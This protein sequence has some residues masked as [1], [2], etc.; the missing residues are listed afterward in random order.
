MTRLMGLFGL[1]SMMVCGLQGQ[2]NDAE[3]V[4]ACVHY[5]ICDMSRI[6]QGSIFDAYASIS[7]P[8]PASVV[9]GFP[10]RTN[11][12]GI[13][14][15]VDAG[16]QT[17]DA[18]I[19]QILSTPTLYSSDT[20][21]RVRAVLPS[22]T[23]LGVASVVVR[24]K[25]TALNGSNGPK[26]L[27]VKRDLG[28][29]NAGP[30]TTQNFSPSGS[31]RVNSFADAATPGQ[32][33]VL[34]GTGL[35][36]VSADEAGGPAPGDL[37]IQDLQVLVANK[38]AHVVYAG[39]SGC[40]AGLDQIMFEVPAETQ[41]CAVP[42]VVRFSDD[43]SE[44]NGISLS[45]AAQSGACPI[46][47][48]ADLT[49]K[50]LSG[51]LVS[52]LLQ[53]SPDNGLS[54]DFTAA[55]TTWRLGSPP[56]PY[57]SCYGTA[58]LAGANESMSYQGPGIRPLDAGRQLTLRTP[59]GIVVLNAQ[60]S[61]SPPAVQSNP[62]RYVADTPP[63]HLA[64]GEFTLDNGNGGPDVGS[65]QSTFSLPD[66]SFVW[67]NKDSLSSVTA[68]QDLTVTWKAGSP[69]GYVEVSGGYAHSPG[70]DLDYDYVESSFDCIERA[71]KG[72]FTIPGSV[73]WRAQGSAVP[74]LVLILGVGN[75]VSRRFMAPTLDVGVFSWFSG[76]TKILKFQ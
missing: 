64:A 13:S 39:R 33:V 23:P 35:G 8:A 38:P 37:G 27:V 17:V 50:Y 56:R 3:H 11:L 26:M 65:F 69:D 36:A 62:L 66:L 40:C 29:Y 59:E 54:A 15:E 75:V 61:V 19:L 28:L 30:S 2:Y 7:G 42:V 14:V 24:Y 48:S 25:G 44:S 60:G 68:S 6:A 71:D 55:A 46:D 47:P 72:T 32:L 63:D 16:D 57:G 53:G 73:L 1:A 67:T 20:S 70:L 52:G 9:S 21:L 58:G 10:L 45:I 12:S 18:L 43:G 76:S 74:D 41:G 4:S 31:L 5:G 49:Q 51:T 22:G 34:W